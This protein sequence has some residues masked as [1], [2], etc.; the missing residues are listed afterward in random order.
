MPLKA[1]VGQAEARTDGR[2]RGHKQPHSSGN[3]GGKHFSPGFSKLPIFIIF[4]RSKP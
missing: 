2:L 1:V 4:Y 3:S